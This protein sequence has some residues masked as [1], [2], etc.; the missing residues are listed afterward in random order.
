MTFA[1][2]S[3]KAMVCQQCAPYSYANEDFTSC[4]CAGG[5]FA[6]KVD[7]TG[8]EYLMELRCQCLCVTVLP[9]STG[10]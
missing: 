2:K 4:V 7:E 3:N 1:P 6:E 8:S 5:Y 10:A 9:L